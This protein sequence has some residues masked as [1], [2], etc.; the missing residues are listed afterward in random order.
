MRRCL[1]LL[2]AACG[3]APLPRVE[4]ETPIPRPVAPASLPI[5]LVPA[6]A[7]PI[8]SRASGDWARAFPPAKTFRVYEMPRAAR[9]LLTWRIGFA[10]AVK[11]IADD[12]EDYP[13]NHVAETSLVVRAAGA[14]QTLSLGE[15]VGS[16]GPSSITYC[17]NRGWR[18]DAD[19][20]WA[21]PKEPSVASA[22]EMSIMQGSDDFILVR[23]GGT[24][25]LLHRETSDGS[26]DEGNQGP[27]DICE[28]FEWSR[29]AEIH[30]GGA[31]LFERIDDAGGFDCAIEHWGERLVFP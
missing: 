1:A 22:F 3:P 5:D 18:V 28:G 10:H 7:A 2:L 9:V 19:G 26:C 12:H 11:E 8:R 29:L 15:L 4:I 14:E 30:V 17:K 25:H 20:C 24:L 16:P 21:F 13:G 23:D 31:D 6:D 27:L